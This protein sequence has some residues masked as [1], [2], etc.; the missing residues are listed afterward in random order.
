MSAPST[1]PGRTQIKEV[2]IGGELRDRILYVDAR[3]AG[4]CAEL[5][6][7]GGF[8]LLGVSEQQNPGLANLDFLKAFFPVGRLHLMLF[9]RLDL[10]VL[11]DASLQHFF[12]NDDVNGLDDLTLFPALVSVGQRWSSR[13]RVD[14][15]LANLRNL[16][17][18]G[19]SPETRRIEALTAMAG[20]ERLSLLKTSITSLDGLQALSALTALSVDSAP[21][22][23]D[24]EAI[25][26]L[27]HLRE[28]DFETC[29]SLRGFAELIQGGDVHRLHYMKCAALPDLRFVRRLPALKRFVFMDTDVIDGDMSPLIEHPTLSRVVFTRKAHFSMSERDVM[30]HIRHRK[31]V[32]H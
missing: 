15:T 32:P 27:K 25:A 8:T 3:Y 10:S 12:S 22:L 24:I 7:S 19:F 29:M 1:L 18:V 26:E 11:R 28:V 17:L 31:V 16:S 5:W 21:K 20:L 23:E 2:V 4:A 14:S 9:R 6:Q 30:K 13:F